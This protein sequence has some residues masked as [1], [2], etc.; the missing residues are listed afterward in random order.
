MIICCFGDS[1]TLGVGDSSGLGWPGRLAQ[2]LGAD[3]TK[4]TLYNLGVRADT[5]VRLGQRWMAEALARS[6]NATD[7]RLVFCVGTADVA[8]HVPP[9]DSTRACTDILRRSGEVG[10]HLLITPPPMADPD[11][12]ARLGALAAQFRTVTERH[13]AAC[14]DL[15][16]ALVENR[17]YRHALERGDGVHPDD[18]GHELLAA[19][20]ASWPPL[21]ALFLGSS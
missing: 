14:F 21:A 17:T 6:N 4:T 2:R 11:K 20:L 13:G 1:L 18:R 8:Q 7:T 9:K 10:S 16:S 15:F 19:T 5:S 12:N 3:L